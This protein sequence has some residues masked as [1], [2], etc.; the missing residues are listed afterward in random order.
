[1]TT[2]MKKLFCI[3]ALLTLFVSVSPAQNKVSGYVIGFYNLENLF[4]TYNDPAHNDEEFLPEGKN[5]WTQAKYQKKVSNMAR[6]IRAM[7]DDNGCWHTILG[8]SEVENRLVIEDLVSQSEIA[9]ANYQIVH[10]DGPD[11]RGVDVALLYRPEQFK[12][13]ESKSIPYTFDSK[14]KFEELNY[15]FGTI[16]EKDGDVTTIFKFKNEGDSPLIITNAQ[17]SCGCTSPVYSKKPIRPGETSEI[18]VTYHAKGRPGPFDKSVYVYS[19]DKQHERVM[20]TI[21]GNV[22]NS[23]DKIQTY[24][25]DLGGGLRVKTTSLNFFDVYPGRPNRTRALMVYNES[26]QPITLTFRNAPKHIDVLCEPEVIKPKGEGRVNVTFVTERAKD[27]GPRKDLF[28]LY[29]KGK[30]TKMK[31][32]HISVLADIWED[33]SNLETEDLQNAPEI[34]VSDQKLKFFREDQ[35]TYK[36]VITIS[37]TGKQKLVIRKISNEKD[38]ALQIKIDDT[39]IKPGETTTMHIT[40]NPDSD[41]RVS[42]NNN[43]TIICNDPRN[44]RVLVNLQ[45][46]K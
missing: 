14:I 45:V 30:E 42:F 33:F 24:T 27:W 3:A 4:D 9:D 23:G 18:K 13:L 43:V 37:N 15:D 26:D 5:K 40:Y 2:T 12:L 41:Q 29:V 1:M 39:V 34:E 31:N 21:T 16:N 22:I 28:D 10:Y 44:S 38:Q 20:L 11:R 36:Q 17:A 35:S 8:I 46:Q 25:E 6:V 32:N 7:H 19:N